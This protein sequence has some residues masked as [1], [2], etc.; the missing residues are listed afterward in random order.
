MSDARP[1]LALFGLGR[2]GRAFARSFARADVEVVAL[3]TRARRAPLDIDGLPSP[4]VGLA[5][6][7]AAAVAGR[8]DAF[9]LCVPD[10][11]IGKVAQSVADLASD[12]SAARLP[13]RVAHISG[14]SGRQALGALGCLSRAACFHPLAALDGKDA[15]PAGALCSVDADD[16]DDVQW[17]SALA[18]DIGLQ[19]V[20][21]P[22]PERAR[23]HL[24]AVVGANLPM[25]LLADARRLLAASG[26]GL[27]EAERGLTVLLRSALDTLDD[28]TPLEHAVTGP[29]ARG[30]ASTI[31]RH[32][33]VLDDEDPALRARYQELSAQLVHLTPHGM[34]ERQALFKALRLDDD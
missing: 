11:V 12:F 4:Q 19:P 5:A 21:I 31:A 23:Y 3:G 9:F 32:M 25:A 24:A 28:D 17:L 30:D 34:A 6:T 29:I 15:L 20:H 26:V 27:R 22:S 33:R 1:R 14:A 8:A 10:D 16:P 2:A 7:L 13:P 18:R